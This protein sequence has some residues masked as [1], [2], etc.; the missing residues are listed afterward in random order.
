MRHEVSIG[1]GTRQKNVT[2]RS[3]QSS[4]TLTLINFGSGES[5]L[6]RS[7]ERNEQDA[8]EGSGTRSWSERRHCAQL[9]IV[10]SEPKKL[11]SHAQGDCVSSFDP[12]V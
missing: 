9:Q 6:R 5:N 7:H 4:V 8:P 12:L 1:N 11:I 3:T 2:S 10:Y